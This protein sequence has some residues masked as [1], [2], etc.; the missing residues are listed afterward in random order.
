[1]VEWLHLNE[2]QWQVYVC[3][4]RKMEGEVTGCRLLVAR[5]PV[6][7][8]WAPVAGYGCWLLVTG[9]HVL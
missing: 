6:G 4:Y 1:M 3:E 9:E 2:C 5:L 7:G 8:Y